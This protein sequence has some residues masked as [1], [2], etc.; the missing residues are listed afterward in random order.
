MIGN[1]NV[2]ATHLNE[3]DALKRLQAETAAELAALLPVH[4]RSRLQRRILIC[5]NES[6]SSASIW[7]TCRVNCWSKIRKSCGNMSDTGR[8]FTHS[9]AGV[10]FIT[11]V[12]RAIYA[13]ASVTI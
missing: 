2:S 6:H 10:K 4:P 11:W 13:V 5:Q 9:I 8:A 12:W 1:S 3:S 7:K